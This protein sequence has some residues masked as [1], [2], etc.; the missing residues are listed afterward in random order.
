MSGSMPRRVLDSP[1]NLKSGATAD[2]ERHEIQGRVAA[3]SVGV[4]ARRSSTDL[5]SGTL[6]F[7]K[8]LTRILFSRAHVV[9]RHRV[10]GQRIASGLILTLRRMPFFSIRAIVIRENYVKYYG[11][12]HFYLIVM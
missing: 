11:R 12:A 7:I 9:H 8:I 2:N 4:K 10:R 3:V 1:C 6:R 5:G